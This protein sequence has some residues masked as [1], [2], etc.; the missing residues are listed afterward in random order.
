MCYREGTGVKADPAEA[1]KWLTSAAE[2][3]NANAQYELGNQLYGATADPA[4]DVI[5]IR[6]FRKSAEQLQAAACFSL[7]NCYLNGRGVVQNKIEGLAWMLMRAEK[8]GRE[9]K[10]ELARILAEFG[11]DEINRASERSQKLQAELEAKLEE[12]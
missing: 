7:G 8:L 4:K 12:K 6:W 5:A 10:D 1:I 11:E 2:K 9:S 3:N